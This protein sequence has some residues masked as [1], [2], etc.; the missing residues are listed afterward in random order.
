M[1][2]PVS[3]E[4]DTILQTHN[5]TK[6]F[7]RRVAVDHIDLEVKRGDV[8]G[9][10][11]Q[12]GSGKTTTIRLLLGLVRPT[13]GAIRIFGMDTT[14][15]LGTILPRLGAL[16]ET[17][18]FYSH[19]SGRD[20]LRV[21]AARSGLNWDRRTDRRIDDVLQLCELSDRAEAAYHT[22]SL[23]MKQRLG[24]G[25][26]LLTDPELVLLDEP[27]NGLDPA[28]MHSMRQLFLQL[29]AR[30]KT[31]FLSSHLLSEVQLVCNRVAILH[32]G[33]LLRQG[34]VREFLRTGRILIRLPMPQQIEPAFVVLQQL[35]G[36][37]LAGIRQ[38][39]QGRD[40]W[41]QPAIFVEAPLDRS[42]EIE[43]I[44]AR[45]DLFPLELYHDQSSLEE[46]FLDLTTSGREPGV[47]LEQTSKLPPQ[48]SNLQ[49]GRT[50]RGSHL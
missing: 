31:V 47:A 21:L 22:Y 2:T 9:F 18:V 41:G 26:A 27:T 44:L 15:H 37:G 3:G 39:R 30:G 20:N 33:R 17:P 23:G 38:I 11:G 6:A 14:T 1:D 49:A 48:S 4:T 25:A 45:H 12:N 24:V 10:L 29:A 34:T 28:G 40:R 43:S 46:F 42:P 50:A 5:L 16:I 13:A 7:G 36:A 19:L 35:Q 8:F 32:Q